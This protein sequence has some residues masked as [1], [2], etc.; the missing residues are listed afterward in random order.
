MQE[1]HIDR[2]VVTK[3]ISGKWFQCEIAHSANSAGGR[4]I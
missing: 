1:L 3:A 2:M 4:Q